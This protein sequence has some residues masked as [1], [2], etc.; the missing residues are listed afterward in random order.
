M[1]TSLGEYEC[2]CGMEFTEGDEL[3]QHI[4]TTHTGGRGVGLVCTKAAHQK[5][6]TKVPVLSEN[7]TEHK[8]LFA[9]NVCYVYMAMRSRPQ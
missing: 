5:P 4:N 8:R 2:H 3:T 6:Y 1:D 9:T 7:I